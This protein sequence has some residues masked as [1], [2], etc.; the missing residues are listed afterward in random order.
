METRTTKDEIYTLSLTVQASAEHS[1]EAWNL[2]QSKHREG[3]RIGR[4]WRD[5]PDGRVKF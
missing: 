1:W 4:V 2:V 5:Q 3:V